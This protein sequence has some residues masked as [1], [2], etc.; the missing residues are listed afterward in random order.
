MTAAV[1]EDEEEEGSPC[2]CAF[3]SLGSAT[4]TADCDMQ[5]MEKGKTAKR[6]P[7]PELPRRSFMYGP[8]MAW[9]ASQAHAHAQ[10]D[11]DAAHE[12]VGNAIRRRLSSRLAADICYCWQ[13]QMDGW[14]YGMVGP[15]LRS[16]PAR[17]LC[18]V[19]LALLP[20]MHD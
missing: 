2:A 1:A 16:R 7:P 10:R 14:K 3:F 6:S 17:A 15:P 18:C 19:F 8:L 13:L 5:P 9:P 12:W 11:T 4:D 20:R